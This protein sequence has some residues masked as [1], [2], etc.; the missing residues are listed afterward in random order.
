MAK[1][2]LDGTDE[3]FGPYVEPGQTEL[4]AVTW[5]QFK[6]LVYGGSVV[7]EGKTVTMANGPFR[8]MPEQQ[9]SLNGQ[10]PD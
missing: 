4:P 7:V 1:L 5:R 8:L 2:T 6:E 9:E 3:G 10:T